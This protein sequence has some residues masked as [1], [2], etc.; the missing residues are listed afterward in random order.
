MADVYFYHHIA[1]PA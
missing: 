1:A